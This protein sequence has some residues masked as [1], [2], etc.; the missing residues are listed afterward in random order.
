M[1]PVDFHRLARAEVRSARPYLTRHGRPGTA[2]RFAAA[3]DDAVNRV[4]AAPASF[5]HD[6][7]GTRMC[8]VR[9]FQ[10]RLVFLIEATRLVVV[11]VS[12]NRRRPGYWVGRLTRP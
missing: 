5:A 7:H 10:Y 1:L 2:T 8:P 6:L 4:V 12:H 11:A 3:V 9:R